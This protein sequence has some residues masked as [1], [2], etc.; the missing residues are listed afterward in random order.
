MIMFFINHPPPT[1]TAQQKGV[2]ASRGRVVHYTKPHIRKLKDLWIKLLSQHKPKNPLTGAL[3]LTLLFK[4]E[5]LKSTPKSKRNML[6]WKDTK[7]DVDNM[8]KLILDAM[9]SAGFWNDD[10]QIAKLHI[11]KAWVKQDRQ[12]LSVDLHEIQSMEDDSE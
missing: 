8:S 2:F 4:F 6:I 10:A 11:S 12:G 5:H 7:P 1:T 9:T 3:S